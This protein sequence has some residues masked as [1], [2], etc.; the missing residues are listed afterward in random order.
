MITQTQTVLSLLILKFLRNLLQSPIQEN[1]GYLFLSF[2]FSLFHTSQ[3]ILF[4]MSFG[5]PLFRIITFGMLVRQSENHIKTV[6]MFSCF[7][8]WHICFFSQDRALSAENEQ[9]TNDTTIGLLNHG[10]PQKKKWY[11]K[12]IS[13]GDYL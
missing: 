4:S 8:I 3:F 2:I 7:V 12:L 13:S 10:E 1:D 5:K 6:I 9:P 11:E